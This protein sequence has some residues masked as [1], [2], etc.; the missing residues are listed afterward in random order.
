MSIRFIFVYVPV[1][2]NNVHHKK[3]G[4][5]LAIQIFHIEN[6]LSV[7]TYAGGNIVDESGESGSSKFRQVVL[8]EQ[9]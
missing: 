6:I 5:V 2:I 8:S 4:F 3:A 9:V 7:D 1:S